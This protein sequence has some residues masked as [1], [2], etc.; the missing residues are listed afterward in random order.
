MIVEAMPGLLSAI[1]GGSIKPLAVTSAKRLPSFPD[2]PT[3]AEFIPG[4]P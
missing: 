2:V 3:V 1:Q 4:F